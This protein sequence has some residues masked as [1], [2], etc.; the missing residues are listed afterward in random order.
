MCRLPWH[1][2]S[3]LACSWPAGGVSEEAVSLCGHKAVACAYDQWP[4]MVDVEPRVKRTVS[5]GDGWVGQED[6]DWSRGNKMLI[7]QVT[8]LLLTC[9]LGHLPPGAVLPY[10]ELW[11]MHLLGGSRSLSGQ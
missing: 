7:P 10:K 3:A 11:K 6:G 2:G 9:C 8:S 5:A 1:P 4:Q